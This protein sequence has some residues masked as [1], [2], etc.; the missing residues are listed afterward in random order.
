MSLNGILFRRKELAEKCFG[1]VYTL[2]CPSAVKTTDMD[3]MWQKRGAV[4]AGPA[5]LNAVRKGGLAMGAGGAFSSWTRQT[6]YN[7]GRTRHLPFS[8]Q[9]EQCVSVK[10]PPCLSNCKYRRFQVCNPCQHSHTEDAWSGVTR[11]LVRK[12]PS[13]W[14]CSSQRYWYWTSVC[15]EGE[16][17]VLEPWEFPACF[18]PKLQTTWIYRRYFLSGYNPPNSFP[19]ANNRWCLEGQRNSVASM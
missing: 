15:T 1:A 14:N 18:L 13:L 11:S 19:L 8:L 3:K 10:H 6:A 4:W 5:G 7:P 9:G 2:F 16:M 17:T 12:C